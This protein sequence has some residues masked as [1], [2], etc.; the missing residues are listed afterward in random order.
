MTTFSC[1]FLYGALN[2]SVHDAGIVSMCWLHD[3]K[4]LLDISTVSSARIPTGH[5]YRKMYIDKHVQRF[6]QLTVHQQERFVEL[7]EYWLVVVKVCC[8]FCY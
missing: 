4:V 2:V 6:V 3:G 5:L 8:L 1:V 7:A